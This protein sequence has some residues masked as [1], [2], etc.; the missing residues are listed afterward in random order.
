M[1]ITSIGYDG[2][3]NESQWAKLIPLA[4]SGHYGVSGFSDWKVTT[5][6]TLDRG[7]SI[8]AGTGW[9]QGVLDTSTT[10][11]SLQGAS[12]G[13]GSRW[14]LI[15]ARRDWSGT[16]GTTSFALIGGTSSK[17]LPSRNTDPGTLDD[18][19][20]AL[21][22]FTAGSSAPTAIVDLRCWARNG[23][24]V[25]RDELALT[26]L[27]KIGSNVVIG[28]SVW[29]CTLDSN[30]NTSWTT[31]MQ[32]GRIPLFGT[33]KDGL[34]GSKVSTLL[35]GGQQFLIQ[36]GSTV[37]KTDASGY[38]RITFQNPFPNGLLTVLGFDGD[39][40]SMGGSALYSSAGSVW[41]GE[42]Y[43]TKASW[44]YALKLQPAASGTGSQTISRAGNRQ[45][46]INWIA[47]GW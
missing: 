2:T 34:E 4:G 28:D 12:V 37:Q 23:G 41:G 33:S 17:A 20:L 22:Q 43:G 21:V 8:A 19:P 16:G 24:M 6:P 18:Q 1:A 10:S 13:S 40:W 42:G 5:H 36:A 27:K 46:R 26:Y 45:H 29:N 25:A 9:G 35:T 3:V 7:V 31:T 30:G 15:V 47:I 39:D 44:V 32:T 11:T 14:D 38:A